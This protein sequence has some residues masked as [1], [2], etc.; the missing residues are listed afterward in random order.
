MADQN[1]GVPV[2]ETATANSASAASATATLAAP[3]AEYFWR[4]TGWSGGSSDQPGTVALKHGATV[5]A[6]LPFNKGTTGEMFNRENMINMPVNAAI[7]AVTTPDAN[8][9]CSANL[10]AQKVHISA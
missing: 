4:I 2:G 1:A 6:T 8:G 3:G 10:K 9:Q 7:T 5:A